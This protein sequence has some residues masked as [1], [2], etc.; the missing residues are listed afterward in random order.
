MGPQETKITILV[1]NQAGAG[2]VAEHGL[3]LWIE[4]E[5]LRIL[6][7]AG[8][9]VALEPNARSLGADL[10]RTDILALSHGHYDHA[11]GIHQVLRQARNAHVYCHPGVVQPRFSIRDGT[12]KSIQAPRESLAAIAKLPERRIRWTAQA[13][14][15]TDRIG[16]TGY[17]PRQTSFEDAGGP[18]YLDPEGQRADPIEDDQALWI[19][20]EA[21]IIVCVGCAHAGLAN[22]LDYVQ[23]LNQGL[24]ISAVIG[25]FHLVNASRE[26]LER[27]A[28]ALQ[29]LELE[30]AV[31][32]HCTGEHAVSS[33]RDALG[34]RVTPGAAGM[35]FYFP[36]SRSSLK[37]VHT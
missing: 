15:L 18:F 14:A 19:R 29:G 17:I 1:D 28:A 12:P 36:E 27:T 7:D 20:T 33:L 9:G 4:T 3:A 24:K 23:R 22:S 26:R 35:T 5:G 30:L 37:Q 6:F 8:Q 25:G 2:L 10:S 34:G 21:G 31:P 13:T 11:G 16:V 32:C